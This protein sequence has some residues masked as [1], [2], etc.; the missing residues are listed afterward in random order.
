MEPPAKRPREA[1][2]SWADY[3]LALPGDARFVVAQTLNLGEVWAICHIN[4]AFF[5]WC[6]AYDLYNKL[7]RHWYGTDEWQK[8]RAFYTEAFGHVNPLWML[9]GYW[10]VREMTVNMT[11][12]SYIHPWSDRVFGT[13]NGIDLPTAGSQGRV[14]VWNV[15]ERKWYSQY[16]WI[17]SDG[18][19]GADFDGIGNLESGS[20]IRVW[21]TANDGSQQVALGWDLILGVSTTRNEVWGY[22]TGNSPVEISL[23]RGLVSGEPFELIGTAA[24]GAQPNGY[25]A[26]QVLAAAASYSSPYTLFTTSLNWSSTALTLMVFPL[27]LDFAIS[28]KI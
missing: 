10:G 22:T 7:F 19:Y 8:T 20:M 28:S 17:E 16:V 26:S 15:H 4:R 2:A 12:V 13:V 11:H 27:W 24:P 25:Y 1:P 6:N 3:M 5:D 9:L 14:D 18:K 23:Y 21:A